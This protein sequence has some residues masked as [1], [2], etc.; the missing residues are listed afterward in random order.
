MIKN[1]NQL[2]KNQLIELQQLMHRCKKVD[3][4]VSNVYLHILSQQRVLPASLLYYE[5]EQLLG[6]LSVYFFYDD[7]VEVALMVDPVKRKQ[8]I[9]KQL[10]TSIVPLI[11]YQEYSRIIF[12]CPALLNDNWFPAKGL[13]YFQSEYY[14]ERDDLSPVL[15]SSEVLSFRPVVLE[16]IPALS[17][18][19]SACFK[20]QH[21]NLVERFEQII[22]NRAYQIFVAVKNNQIIGKA[23]LRW[24]EKGATLSDIGILPEQQGKG[25]GTALIAYCINHALVEGKPL[26]NLDV[27][28]HNL[29]A[30]NLY[31]Q[32]GFVTQNACD[33]WEIEMRQLQS[34]IGM[35]R[36]F[37]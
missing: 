11:E 26:L 35:S 7:A 30:L 19:D 33:Y 16:D 25:Y 6:F 37:E 2:N 13:K 24:Q 5:E 20:Q 3:G 10:I 36:V 4:S 21:K 28:T 8:G 27:E 15:A 29:K 1:T 34:H 18:I 17:A 23:H 12:S 14:M 9:A 32:L 31:T 22:E